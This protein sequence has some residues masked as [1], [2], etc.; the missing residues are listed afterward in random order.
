MTLNKNV[1]NKINQLYITTRNKYLMQKDGG[2][3]ITLTKKPDNKV[4][5]LNDAFIATHLE[6]KI[7]YGVFSAGHSSKF[8]TF[9]VDIAGDITQAKWTTQRLINILVE[10]F[11]IGYDEMHVSFSG[12]KGYHVDIFFDE[13]IE[14][15][16]L[17]AFYNEV[18][19][20]YGEVSG[21]D[22]EF[23]PSYTQG[24]KLPLGVH[25][26]TGKRAWYCDIYTLEPI[27][28]FA[29]ILDIEPVPAETITERD[30]Y[31]APEVDEVT[32]MVEVVS[33]INMEV[34][35]YDMSDAMQKVAAVIEEG[36]LPYP[37]SRH[38]Y[39]YLLALFAN[40]NG[41]EK[42]DSIALIM[43]VL[44]GTPNEYFSEGSTP[45][46]WKNEAVRLTDYVF[47]N[48]KVLTGM[49]SE[50]EVT[51]AEMTQVLSAGTFKQKQVAFAM[52]VHSKRYG[53]K[54]YMTYKQITDMTGIGSN[55][56]VSSALNKLN[57]NGF[58]EFVRKNEAD[59]ASLKNGIYKSLPNKYLIK[60]VEY[61]NEQQKK[62]V[63]VGADTD[64]RE[65]AFKLFTVQEVKQFVKRKEFANNWQ[66]F[67][68]A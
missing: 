20:E 50:V 22:I 43:D 8:I 25:H 39:T 42:S 31:E 47:D 15:D 37:N 14:V 36:K 23:R 35:T 56:T 27:E 4:I 53:N 58:M 13:L 49:S 46:H 28:D 18:M 34:G 1:I 51:K 16:T 66:G 30:V 41:L 32:G 10:Q 61:E 55:H 2:Q 60:Q 26:K 57:E 11:N 48:D 33:S 3:Y 24:V 9:D 45:E 63:S 65:I 62:S 19:R 17:R 40:T 44:H 67:L 29:Y 5:P 21:G 54:F 68:A 52:L 6:G 64:L 7:T 38:N 59:K 12:N